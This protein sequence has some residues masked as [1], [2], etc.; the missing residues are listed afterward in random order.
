M[1]YKVLKYPIE[2]INCENCLEDEKCQSCIS[3]PK[4]NLFDCE[5]AK[6]CKDC[7]KKT[8]IETYSTENNKLKRQS[9]KE[10][11]YMLPH[12]VENLVE[13]IK[14][15]NQECYKKCDKCFVEFKDEKNNK[16]K[17]IC[18]RCCNES[19]RKKSICL[20]FFNNESIKYK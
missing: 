5:V 18:G 8:Q 4:R 11:G 15:K 19:R 10:N 17:R 9:P 3:D 2:K 13:N 20:I 16:N 1:N 14:E 12:Y 6:S 7:Y